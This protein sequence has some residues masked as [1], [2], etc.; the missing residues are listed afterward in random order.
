MHTYGDG[1]KFAPVWL[2][3]AVVALAGCRTYG[4][5]DATALT[6]VQIEQVHDAFARALERSRAEYAQ[7]Q[8]TSAGEREQAVDAY[9]AILADHEALLDA[10]RTL[11][12]ALGGPEAGYRTVHRVYGMMLSEQQL[13]FARYER[14]HLRAAAGEG[15]EAVAGGM[16]AL[17]YHTAPPF[18]QRLW[19]QEPGAAMR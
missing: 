5:H 16:E 3:V 15:T 18:Y 6:Y 11:V 4:A 10:H 7:L 17:P 14:W 12:E 13:I 2:L 1:W 19:R 8:R 9:R